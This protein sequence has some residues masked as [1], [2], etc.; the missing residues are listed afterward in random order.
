MHQNAADTTPDPYYVT[1]LFSPTIS[2]SKFAYTHSS[3]DDT[4]E[5]NRPV[6]TALGHTDDG[7]DVGD[8]KHRGGAAV[9]RLWSMRWAE[10]EWNFAVLRAAALAGVHRIWRSGKT[11][12]KLTQARETLSVAFASE[13]TRLTT[14]NGAEEV[15]AS[16]TLWRRLEQ[17]VQTSIAAE[18]YKKNMTCTEWEGFLNSGSLIKGQPGYKKWAALQEYCMIQGWLPAGEDDPRYPTDKAIL[19]KAEAAK[20]ALHDM[21]A[22]YRVMVGLK[23][24]KKVAADVAVGKAA[25]KDTD[26]LALER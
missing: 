22:A 17:M 19:A 16:R 10:P 9:A 3:M 8:A 18:E 5:A 15:L 1:P 20:E 4:Q 11:H 6:H 21:C 24:G 12:G 7:D 13:S 14:T 2:T 23:D 25:R 26:G